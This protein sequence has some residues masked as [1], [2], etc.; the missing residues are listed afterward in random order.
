MTSRAGRP[1]P[2]ISQTSKKLRAIGLR[3]LAFLAAVLVVTGCSSVSVERINEV[4]A[5]TPASRPKAVYVRPFT[6]PVGIEFNAAPAAGETDARD[7]VGRL[8]A[9]GVL[10]KADEWIAP[11]QLLEPGAAVPGGGLLIEGTVRRTNQGSRALRVGIGFGAGRS[12][13]ETAVRVYYLDYSATEPWLTFRTTGG[14][15]IEPGLVGMLVPS[16]VAIPVAAS[17]L[18][19]VVTAGAI[20]TKGV[21]QDAMRTG[22]MVAAAVHDRLAAASVVKRQ[23]RVKTPGKIPVTGSEAEVRRAE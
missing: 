19:G 20:G 14:S 18:G 8:V 21:T 9:E 12:W 10:S 1:C 7:R 22:R 16:P 4:A 3:C 6:V 13:F 17:L 15:N 11:G 23:A 5:L 2:L